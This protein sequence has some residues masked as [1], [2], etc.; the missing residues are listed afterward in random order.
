MG[1][2]V[3]F[4]QQESALFEDEA[5]VNRQVCKSIQLGGELSLGLYYALLQV[6]MRTVIFYVA[7]SQFQFWI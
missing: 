3:N 4:S 6:M 5:C 2:V 7:Y 1:G